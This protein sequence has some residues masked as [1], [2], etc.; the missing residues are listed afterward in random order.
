MS[1]ELRS[2][3]IS[4]GRKSLYLDIYESGSRQYEFLKLYLLP[5][6]NP[7]NRQT[8][9]ETLKLAEGI[10]AKRQISIKNEE[11]GFT[12]GFKKKANFIEYF[13]AYK[14]NIKNPKTREGYE[15]AYRHLKEFAG[16]TLPFTAITS[17]WIEK[18][19]TYLTNANSAYGRT[20]IKKISGT[21]AYTYMSRIRT[22]Y[23]KALKEKII[24]SDSFS[25][26]SRIKTEPSKTVFLELSE[27]EL[28][29]KTDCKKSDVKRAFLFSCFTGLRYSD[30]VALKWK[31]I[32]NG[33]IEII[34]KKSKKSVTVPLSNTARELLG[35][36]GEAEH[37][38]FEMPLP[39]WTEKILKDWSNA[40][41]I[42]KHVTFHVSR[43]T[44]AT[45]SLT[46][47]ADLYTV[48][49]LLGHANIQTTQIYAKVIDEKKKQAIDLLPTLDIWGDSEPKPNKPKYTLEQ[50]KFKLL[51]E[52]S[53]EFTDELTLW[54]LMEQVDFYPELKEMNNKSANYEEF[55]DLIIRS[56]KVTG[57]AA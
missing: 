21:S 55:K 42:K 36:T 38:I 1:V 18:F 51:S 12:A 7:E 33:N 2:K 27:I 43:H 3:P 49:K 29:L 16:E 45:L 6:T 4:K 44:F 31:N 11:H 41:G 39:S 25:D 37:H 20:A 46:L 17:Q 56:L 23:N 35:K 32:Q 13:A 50:L 9:K 19:K 52:L 40:A 14:D 24:I 28:L 5:V 54:E 34:Q 8:N 10:R 15:S 53:E 57:D 26:I 48:S 30:I 47:G 22:V